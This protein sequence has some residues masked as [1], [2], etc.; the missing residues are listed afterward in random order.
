MHRSTVVILGILLILCTTL[1][2]QKIATSPAPYTSPASGEEMYKAYCASCHGLD[3]KGSGPAAVASK[4]TV[5]D[6]TRLSTANQGKFP[7][8]RIVQ[9]IRGDTNNASHGSKEM[10][11]WGPVFLKMSQHQPGEVHQRVQNLAKY[12]EGMQAK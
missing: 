3:G 11:V 12:I 8:D 10:P 7:F 6:L 2:G 5:P 9:V 4:N 1:T